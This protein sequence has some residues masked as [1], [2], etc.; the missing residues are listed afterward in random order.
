MAQIL[1]VDDSE[2]VTTNLASCLSSNGFDV[3]TAINGREGINEL[4]ADPELRLIISDVNM[5][6]MDGL[7]MAEHIRQEL[8]NNDIMIV[9]LTTESNKAMKAR[10]KAAGVKGWIVKPFHCKKLVSSIRTLLE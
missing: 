2:T 10:A 5:P 8:N 4:R 3:S 9:M 7:T 6:I 1:V